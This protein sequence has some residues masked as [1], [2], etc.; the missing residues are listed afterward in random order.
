MRMRELK[1]RGCCSRVGRS[2][3]Y[4]VTTPASDADPAA[5]APA[6]LISA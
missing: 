5:G 1:N 3:A 2:C 4:L 6:L